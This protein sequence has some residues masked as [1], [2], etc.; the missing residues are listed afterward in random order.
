[1]QGQFIKLVAALAA[2]RTAE[3]ADK[4][5]AEV[6][7]AVNETNKSG[8]ITLKISI[9]PAGAKM[10]TAVVS[11]ESSIE[12]KPPRHPLGLTQ[13]FALE[14]GELSRRHP[15]QAELKFTEAEGEEV[16]N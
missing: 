14:S 9:Q 11:F 15:D 6:V 12:S 10:G 5:L 8:S 3:E 16:N 7:T 13:F 4:Q 1:M 2:G